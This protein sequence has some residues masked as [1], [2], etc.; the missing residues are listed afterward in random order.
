M[1]LGIAHEFPLPGHSGAHPRPR[2]IPQSLVVPERA[3]QTGGVEEVRSIHQLEVKVRRR[4]VPG[5]PDVREMLP[6]NGA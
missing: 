5:V 3:R 4:R 2:T 6:A 1:L